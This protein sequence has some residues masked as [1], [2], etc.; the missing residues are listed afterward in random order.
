M[1]YVNLVSGNNF[2]LICSLGVPWV[3]CTFLRLLLP[4]APVG[5]VGKGQCAR[6]R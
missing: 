3:L 5:F 6:L 1:D 4:Q 2:L